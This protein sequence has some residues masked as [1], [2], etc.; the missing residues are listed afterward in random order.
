MRYAMQVCNV[1]DN[2]RCPPKVAGR[3]LVVD[4]T[5]NR[6][7][8][9]YQP[10]HEARDDL[11]VLST[12]LRE[13]AEEGGGQSLPPRGTTTTTSNRILHRQKSELG[14][15]AAAAAGLPGTPR[16]LKGAPGRGRGGNQEAEEHAPPFDSSSR[17][18]G[19]HRG[20]ARKGNHHMDNQRDNQRDRV[21][22]GRGQQLLHPLGGDTSDLHPAP[23]QHSS[24]QQSNQNMSSL[25]S[26][27]M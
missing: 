7:K 20:G 10:L 17:G 13:P 5:S 3:C 6:I 4:T 11:E 12:E 1:L 14:E 26:K 16:R 2:F 15:A 24:R 9:P 23:S 8:R 25:Y 27:T 21:A 19:R 22:G 18:Q